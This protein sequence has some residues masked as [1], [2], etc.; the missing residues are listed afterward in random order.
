MEVHMVI[1]DTPHGAAVLDW[2]GLQRL[3]DTASFFEPYAVLPLL[4]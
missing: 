3:F 2:R 1:V 4:S